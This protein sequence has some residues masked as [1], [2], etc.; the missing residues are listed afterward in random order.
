M[1]NTPLH[2]FSEPPIC[3]GPEPTPE[4]EGAE[5]ARKIAQE[6]ADAFNGLQS[7]EDALINIDE[8]IGDVEGADSTLGAPSA[9]ILAAARAARFSP[10]DSAEDPP[11]DA[12]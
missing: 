11:A 4:I 6:V 9:D 12:E 7:D 2:L 8:I 5:L 10:D 1:A 3:E